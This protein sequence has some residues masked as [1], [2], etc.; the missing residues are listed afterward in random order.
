MMI[1]EMKMWLRSYGA[2]RI[3]YRLENLNGQF[4]LTGPFVPE[5]FAPFTRTFERLGVYIFVQ[6]TV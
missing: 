5:H 3:F 1:F 4:V 2:G 6:F